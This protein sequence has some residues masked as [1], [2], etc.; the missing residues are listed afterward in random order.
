[1]PVDYLATVRHMYDSINAGNLDA[2]GRDLADDFVEHEVQPGIPATK[3]GVLTFFR[4]LR[5]AF[6]DLQM[7]AEEIYGSENKVVARVT[8]MGTHRGDFMGIP[9]TGRRVNVE[10]IDMFELDADG[11]VGEHWG[12]MDSMALMQ[13]L[14]QLPMPEPAHA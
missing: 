3:E 8:C 6:P 4:A 5:T 13:Q 2:F 14:G 9:A 12:V 10:L 11:R 7:R 1:M